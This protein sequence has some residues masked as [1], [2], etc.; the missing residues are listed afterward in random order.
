MERSVNAECAMKHTDTRINL[1]QN[2]IRLTNYVPVSARQDLLRWWQWKLLL[3]KSSTP[4]V[5][6]TGPQVHCAALSIGNLPTAPPKSQRRE[7]LVKLGRLGDCRRASPRIITVH[8]A[9]LFIELTQNNKFE[10]PY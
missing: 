7:P 1:F 8:M 5:S 10:R 4:C 6:T 9:H 2:M 3:D